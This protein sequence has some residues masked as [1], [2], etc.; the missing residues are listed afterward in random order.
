MGFTVKNL[1]KLQPKRLVF[2]TDY[3]SP[4]GSKDFKKE[5]KHDKQ[6]ASIIIDIILAKL[7][8]ES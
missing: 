7:W 4:T 6:N 8:R 2:S 3:K 1:T 5:I